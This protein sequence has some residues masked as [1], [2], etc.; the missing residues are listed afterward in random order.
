ML[1]L[2]NRLLKKFTNDKNYGKVRDHFHFT[3]KYRSAAHSICNLRFN[4]P[5]EIPV[6]F[7]MGQ[8]MISFYH[9][10]ISKRVWGTISMPC[11]EHRKV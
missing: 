1:N 2:W 10:R 4:V 8:T 6:I 5:N 7:T 11:G 9:K 3:G